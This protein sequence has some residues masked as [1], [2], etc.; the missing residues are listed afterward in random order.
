M[1]IYSTYWYRVAD[2]KPRLRGHAKLCR[3]HYRGEDWYV[4]LD[5]SAN[6]QHRFNTGAYSI[7]TRMDGQ[8]TLQEIWEIAQETLEDD[9][10]TQD[11][12]IQL[13]GQLHSC[14][15]LESNMIA[16]DTELFERQ[17]VQR[18]KWKKYFTNPFA[19]RFPLIDPDR[20]LARMMFLVKPFIGYVALILWLVTVTGAVVVAALH[21]AELTHNVA[22]RLLSPENLLLLWLVYPCVKLLHEIGHAFTVKAWGGEVHEMGIMVL[23]LSPLPYVEAS[24]SSAFPEKKKRIGVA[25]AGMM[26]ELFLASIAL[27]V[28][29]SVEVGLVSVLAYNV[30]L[31]GGISTILFNGNPLLRFDGYYVLSDLIEIPNLAQ[32]SKRYL[33]FVFKT[34]L[35][36]IKSTSPVTAQGEEGWFV[37]YGIASFIYRIFIILAL[38]LFISGKFFIVGVLIAIWGLLTQMVIPAVKSVSGVWNSM[39][40]RRKRSR[41][42][43]LSS[44]I[45]G[46]MFLLLFVVP[47]PLSTQ[48]PGVVSVPEHAR[49]QAGTDCFIAEIFA[50]SGSTV[51]AGQ[52]LLRCEDH[53]LEADLAVKIARLEEVEARYDA[54]PL[55]SRVRREIFKEQIQTEL[56]EV[57]RKRQMLEELVVHSA[58]EGEFVLPQAESLVGTFVPQ[59]GLIGYVVGPS[60]GKAVLVVEQAQ[61]GLI[62]DNT[63]SV[64]LRFAG[65]IAHPLI[66]AVERE[67][68]GASERL[69]SPALGSAG[70]GKIPVDPGDPAGT[71]ALRKVFTFEVGLPVGADNL[72]IGERVYAKFDHGLE[73]IGF[74][75][76]RSIRRLFLR[77]FNV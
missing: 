14:D 48:V 76:F 32:R 22:D 37:C 6:R 51:K 45:A 25:A 8:H 74:Q 28:W 77:Q 54:E 4:L 70:G 62:R 57:E 9:A 40:G 17:S 24:S 66:T 67:V 73:P 15:I 10:P 27:F 20:Y 47:F 38:A 60:E 11:E 16:D 30:M 53:L 33:G 59:G 3:H 56:A 36:G 71:K 29:V 68:P 19:L 31:I 65:Q 39:G 64:E 21:W 23:A 46:L 44:A 75:W 34:Y 43:A 13:L 41:I 63:K 12:V 50:D 61:L 35:L 5:R 42:V 1:S 26:V 18:G 69:P 55:R 7:I 49:V 72:R 2:A 58:S 52:P